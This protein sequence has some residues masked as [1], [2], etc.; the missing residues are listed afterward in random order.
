MQMHGFGT[1]L[2]YLSFG[3][4]SFQSGKVDH[5][6]CEKQTIGFRLV[7]YAPFRKPGGTF[8]D[9]HLVDPRRNAEIWY[10]DLCCHCQWRSD[11][12][13]DKTGICKPT[14]FGFLDTVDE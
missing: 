9:A 13:V 5:V 14:N 7:F 1:E 4:F 10:G 11:G 2:F 12:L 8:F 3:I 6:Q